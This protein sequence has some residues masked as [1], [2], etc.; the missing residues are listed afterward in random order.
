METGRATPQLVFLLID[1]EFDSVAETMRRISCPKYL[2]FCRKRRVLKWFRDHCRSLK[3]ARSGFR[4]E[5]TK[6]GDVTSVYTNCETAIGCLSLHHR[7]RTLADEAF[8]V[9]P[10]DPMCFIG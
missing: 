6:K 9:A 7:V 3:I 10:S 1:V 5:K 2:S 4:R 8:H